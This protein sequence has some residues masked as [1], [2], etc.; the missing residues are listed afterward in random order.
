MR[1]SYLV[2][3]PVIIITIF[4]FYYT[5]Y[6]EKVEYMKPIEKDDLNGKEFILVN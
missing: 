5:F 6:R 1:K 4:L 3:I 2:V